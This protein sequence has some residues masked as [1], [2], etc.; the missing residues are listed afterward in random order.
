[1]RPPRLSAILLL[2]I[3]S[4]L[5]ETLTTKVTVNLPKRLLFPQSFSPPPP[6]TAVQQTFVPGGHIASKL[7]GTC[8][9]QL[10]MTSHV[11]LLWGI[12]CSVLETQVEAVWVEEDLLGELLQNV[13]Q[14]L[15]GRRRRKREEQVRPPAHHCAQLTNVQAMGSS[16]KAATWT[17]L[18][19]L[20]PLIMGHCPDYV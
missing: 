17:L 3:R 2:A 18:V 11:D 6:C 10:N 5:L 1:M 20:L 13:K 19:S 7:A 16:V 12:G 14:G 9:C 8:Q 4:F 15:G